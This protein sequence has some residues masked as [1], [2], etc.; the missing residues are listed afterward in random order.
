MSQYIWRSNKIEEN[1]LR[2][3]E[4]EVCNR[5]D[6]PVNTKVKV[7]A[8][9]MKKDPPVWIAAD[10]ECM[11]IA[12]VKFASDIFMEKVFKNKPLALDY[13]ITKNLILQQSN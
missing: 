2:C 4:E 11:N 3:K 7:K 12:A 9:F 1:M 10:F 6:M 5:S 8:W 13:K